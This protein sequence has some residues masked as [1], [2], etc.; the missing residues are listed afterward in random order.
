ML[1]PQGSKGQESS[2]GDA[3][4]PARDICQPP[5]GSRG[6]PGSCFRTGGHARLAEPQRVVGFYKMSCK[7]KKTKGV[8]E[9]KDDVP[10]SKG[11][12][13]VAGGGVSVR[14]RVDCADG[15]N[16]VMEIDPPSDASDRM[17]TGS[18]RTAVKRR[19]EV[20]EADSASAKRGQ[21]RP[22]RRGGSPSSKKRT[23]VSPSLQ[24]RTL[25]RER[26]RRRGRE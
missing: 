12:G 20:A 14:M 19:N 15:E 4:P 3:Y 23:S 17:S 10:I 18:G 22:Q 5:G 21:D 13:I 9:G 2:A 26:N 7:I 24:A 11:K 16:S 1:R 6:P 8:E 25:P